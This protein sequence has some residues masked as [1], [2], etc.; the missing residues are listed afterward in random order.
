MKKLD[1]NKIEV[2]STDKIIYK[3]NTHKLISVDFQEQLFAFKNDPSDFD[4]ELSWVRCENAAFIKGIATIK[5]DSK[6]KTKIELMA[7]KISESRDKLT[8]G[9][10][11]QKLKEYKANIKRLEDEFKIG[12]KDQLLLLVEAGISW[13]AKLIHARSIH[14]GSYILFQKDKKQLK[15]DFHSRNSYRYEFSPAGI[16]NAVYGEWNKDDFILFITTKLL[17]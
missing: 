11:D 13:S 14:M 7:D 1:F 10:S 2:C 17:R 3:G 9:V 4:E 16:G 5:S 8:K 6:E 12:F 15:M